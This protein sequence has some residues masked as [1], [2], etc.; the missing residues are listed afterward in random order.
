MSVLARKRTLSQYQF[1][2]NAI[3]LRKKI[4]FL[5]LRDFG[6]KRKVRSLGVRTKPMDE[7]TLH[8]F[9]GIAVKYDMPVQLAEYP[10]WLCDTAKGAIETA[11]RMWTQE[12]TEEEREEFLAIA[13]SYGLAG[14]SAEYPE[15][16]VSK[17]RSSIWGIMQ[18]MLLNITRAYTI[19]AT[20]DAEAKERRLCQDRAIA[21]CESLLK[22]FELAIDVFLVNADKYMPYVD[23]I[24]KEIA[25]LKGWRK[26][27]NE[28]NKKNFK[29]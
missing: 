4:I 16:L 11:L 19:W 8:R 18:D 20:N 28:R 17:M 23:D 22:E 1:Y 12:M 2:T 29:K 15:W 9:V 26:S 27:D 7:E 21:D 10:G 25:L 6:I 13:Y 5:L 14:L 3:S 24:N